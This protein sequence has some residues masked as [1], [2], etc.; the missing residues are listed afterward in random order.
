M[1]DDPFDPTPLMAALHRAVTAARKSMQA[2]GFDVRGLVVVANA[3]HAA[4]REYVRSAAAFPLNAWAEHA[5]MLREGVHVF[6]QA[7]RA[8]LDGKLELPDQN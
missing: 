2:D 8:T 1:E 4:A 7:R 5:A 3:Q 6:E